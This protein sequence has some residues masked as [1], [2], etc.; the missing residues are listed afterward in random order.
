M[1]SRGRGRGI[2]NQ[3]AWM[4][5][6]EATTSSTTTTTTSGGAAGG[7]PTSTTTTATTAA[8]T[9]SSSSPSRYDRRRGDDRDRDRGDWRGDRRDHHHSRGP[10]H[11]FGGGGGGRRGPPPSR[12]GGRRG[13]RDHHRGGGGG[14]PP[15]HNPNLIVFHSYEEERD[16]IEHRRSKRLARKSLFDAMPTEEQTAME[17]LQKA[18]LASHGPNPNVFL[19]PEDRVAGGSYG[20]GIL[21]NG[22]GGSVGSAGSGGG[23]GSRSMMMTMQPQQTRHARRLYIGQ[24]ASD[25]TDRDVHAFFREAVRTALGKNDEENGSHNNNTNNDDDDDDDPIISVYMNQERHFAFV[26]FKSMDVTTACLSLNGINMRNKGKIIVKR[27]NDYNPANAP[28][29]SSE[30]M[31]KFDVSKL[32]IVSSIVPDS[33]NKIF[34]GGL[35][36]HLN[37]EQVME[38]LGAFGK[39]KAFHLV[40]ND[41][42][43]VTS[44]GY[45]FVEY[46]DEKV[47][48]VAIM[49][50]NG[51]DMGAGKVLS[52]KIAS[53][54]KEG[55]GEEI[56]TAAIAGALAA[57]TPIV[58]MG[59]MMMMYSSSSSSAG[60]V[61]TAPP[62]MRIVD[63]VD[64]EAL[65]DLAM[66][67]A[68][69]ASINHASHVVNGA[70]GGAHAATTISAPAP[71]PTNPLDIANAA[72]QAVYGNANVAV[73][74][75]QPNGNGSSGKTRIVV[76]LNMVTDE[77]FATTE[78]YEGLKDE[79]KEECEKFGSLISMVIPHPKVCTNHVFYLQHGSFIYCIIFVFI[80]FSI[81]L[82]SLST[83]WV[84]GFIT[85][86]DLFRVCNR[87]RCNECRA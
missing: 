30:F 34:I 58:P 74:P 80:T 67:N 47:T 15:R 26:E 49:G 71:A 8:P 23:G 62:V 14:G 76:L 68:N 41:A 73:A 10:R 1:S 18:A 33:P 35:P 19:R 46:A 61:S 28:A 4:T 27:P 16:W 21:S 2:S 24:I 55:E 56:G 37:E 25:L 53:K 38:L 20:T 3:P 70:A 22:G 59:D 17:E 50:L 42:A 64:V 57:V 29:A 36:Y 51:M 84:C 39:I 44:K 66:G 48:E 13:D 5:R 11:N 86:K 82:M 43:A 75:S 32:G 85:E 78:D 63:G 69:V 54:R 81:P 40:K 6:G 45:C 31:R 77:D 12:G 72:L 65:V 83:G 87:E 60:G 9:P 52:A 7:V 79:V